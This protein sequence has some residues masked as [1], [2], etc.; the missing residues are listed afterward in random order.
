MRRA[1][2][3]LGFDV[4]MKTREQIRR[5][6]PEMIAAGEEITVRSVFAK[7]GRG[8]LTTIHDEIRKWRQ[9][10]EQASREQQ[11]E[12]ECASL[13]LAFETERVHRLQSDK[14]AMMWKNRLVDF[15]LR[16]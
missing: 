15:L 10:P 13:R 11:L 12:I 4:A 6:I 16:E 5:I 9:H 8:S 14:M 3:S 7:L 2:R 1:L